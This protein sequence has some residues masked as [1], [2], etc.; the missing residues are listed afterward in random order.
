M[1]EKLSYLKLIFILF[2]NDLKSRKLIINNGWHKHLPIGFV[3]IYAWAFFLKHNAFLLNEIIWF[4]LF[5]VIFSWLMAC[6]AFEILQNLYAKIK[7]KNRQDNTHSF[8]DV[9]AGWFFQSIAI[10]LTYYFL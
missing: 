3:C 10:L 8:K 4:Q 5:V 9:L 2:F 6:I 7:G 1:K